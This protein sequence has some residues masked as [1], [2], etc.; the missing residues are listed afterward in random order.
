MLF[1]K[2]LGSPTNIFESPIYIWGLWWKLWVSDEVFNENP[3][4]YKENLRS[5]DK[6]LGVF[7]GNLWVFNTNMEVS[8]TN[9]EVSNKIGGLQRKSLAFIND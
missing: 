6:I 4:F 5:S 8:N 1:D 7:Y 3:V 9:M 2:I